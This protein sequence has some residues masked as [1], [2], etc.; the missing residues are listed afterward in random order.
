MHK[1]PA[2]LALALVITAL[3][4]AWADGVVDKLMTA[5]DKAKLENYGTVRSEAIAEARSSGPAADLA[6]FEAVLAKPFESFQGFDMTGEWQCRTIK[7]GG[8]SA[9]IVYGWFK[10][11]VTD[12]GAG[13]LLEK[14]TGSQ[15]TRG[16][17]YDESD[18]RL[19]Y[20]GSFYVAGDPVPA[21]GAGPATDQ[22]GYA[23]RTGRQE[24]RIELPSPYYESKL[25]M[26]EFRR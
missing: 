5:A 17:F 16:R 20:L 8:L 9:L 13:W 18:K 1:T 2:L 25:D 24:W 26:L 7:A 3:A 15:R 14:T 19:I 21:Y 11:S 10:C 23:F 6:T 22:V 4:P 12:D